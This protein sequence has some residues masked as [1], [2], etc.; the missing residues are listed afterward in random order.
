MKPCQIV[1]NLEQMKALIL[2]SDGVRLCGHTSIKEQ[3]RK[4]F[5]GVLPAATPAVR[6][7]RIPGEI[8]KP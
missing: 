8:A 3:L 1:T 5:L 4:S 7:D 6:N 2:P